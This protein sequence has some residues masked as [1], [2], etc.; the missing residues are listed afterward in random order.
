MRMTILA[1][2]AI[3]TLAVTLACG[4]SAEEE[5]LP[6]PN[7]NESNPARWGGSPTP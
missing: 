1:L 5:T 3:L 4:S 2:L 7:I 6:N